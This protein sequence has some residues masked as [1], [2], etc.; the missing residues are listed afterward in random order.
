MI[1]RL[2]GVITFLIIVLLTLR[3]KPKLLGLS[4]YFI[5]L[6]VIT[7]I[8]INVIEL[9]SLY[10]YTNTD[11]LTYVQ[12]WLLF[13]ILMIYGI[14][15]KTLPSFLGFIRPRKTLG[16]TSLIVASISTV[17]GLASIIIPMD[18]LALPIFFNVVLL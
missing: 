1:L 11:S 10:R 4:D 7:L 18:S 16:T 6:S 12:Y 5:A 9:L 17:L 13:P 8:I 2:A 3:I 14:E 15:Y